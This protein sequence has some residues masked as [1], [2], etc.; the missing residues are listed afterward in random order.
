MQIPA[1]GA[2]HPASLYPDS[3]APCPPAVHLRSLTA[4][5]EV[6]CVP[7]TRS[8]VSPVLGSSARRSRSM[9]TPRSSGSCTPVTRV[10][11]DTDS[12][13]RQPGCPRCRSSPTQPVEMARCRPAALHHLCPVAEYIARRQGERPSARKLPG[14]AKSRLHRTPHSRR[15]ALAV[16]VE[17]I[18]EL[19]IQHIGRHMPL[20]R[21][22]KATARDYRAVIRRIHQRLQSEPQALHLDCQSY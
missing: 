9:P 20:P 8:S 15:I 10:A 21:R 3:P 1:K 2:A 19:S 5:H 18:F 7:H 22:G 14:K 4:A 13:P 6:P 11:V 16:T 12:H 17:E